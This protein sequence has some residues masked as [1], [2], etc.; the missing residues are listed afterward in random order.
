MQ[1]DGLSSIGT[2]S[3]CQKPDPL[4]SALV[5]RQPSFI[6]TC[7]TTDNDSRFGRL[8]PTEDAE[9]M[10]TPW[11]WSGGYSIAKAEGKCEDAYFA[12]TC[13]C[14]VA[15][16][17][18]SMAQFANHGVDAAAYAAELMAIAAR[19]LRGRCDTQA[20]PC[21]MLGGALEAVEAAEKGVTAYGAST[22]TVLELS[23]LTLDIANL[24]DSGFMVIR[25]NPLLGA[26]EILARSTSQQHAWNF[27]YQLLRVPPTLRVRLPRGMRTDSARDC[28]TL[29]MAVCPGDLVLLFTDG[30]TDNLHDSDITDIVESEC[31]S[32]G[33]S[34]PEALAQKLALAAY[35]RSIDEVAD[36]PFAREAR[37]NGM[38]SYCGGKI[39]DVTVV[40]AWVMPGAHSASST[41]SGEEEATPIALA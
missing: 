20:S 41:P 25:K 36:T 35:N 9:E 8:S 19:S 31:C 16:G 4:S 32:G 5:R 15:D 12:E 18:G 3:C 11:L 21:S 33:G 13:G 26:F 22:I 24:G 6:S 10:S 40:A 38:P 37:E 2:V 34:P 1:C 28:A 7:S 30:V 17:V 23:G 29:K 14:G 39:D 27:P